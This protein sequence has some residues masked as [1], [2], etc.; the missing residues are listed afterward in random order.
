MMVWEVLTSEASKPATRSTSV[1]TAAADGTCLTY[2][3]K[4]I[5]LG[6]SGE[7]MGRNSLIMPGSRQCS[8]RP[9]HGYVDEGG[10][11]GPLGGS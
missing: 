1:V 2:A 4:L 11:L 3:V 9:S 8:E 7:I 10:W 6:C 5:L